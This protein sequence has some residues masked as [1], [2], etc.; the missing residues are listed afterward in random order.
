[1]SILV[2]NAGSSSLKFGLFDADARGTL[3]SGLIDWTADP[4]R[5]SL[6][7]QRPGMDDVRSQVEVSDHRTALVHAVRSLVETEPVTEGRP[8]VIAAIGHRVVHGGAVFRDSV[9]IDDGVKAA[10]AGFAELAPLHNPPALEGIEAA[11]A[12]LPDVPHVAV[13]DTAFHA[14]LP[15]SACIYPL[16]YEWYTDWGIRRFGFHGISHAYCASRAAELLDRDLSTLRLVTCHLGNGCSATAIRGGVSVATT[17]GFTPMEGLMMGSRSGS[18]DPGILV[19][20]QQHRGLTAGQ[21]D[22]LLNH[23]SGLLGVS[24]VSSD[25]RQVEAAAQ[26]GH[27]RARLSLEMYAGR[28][29]SAVGALSVTMGGVDALIFTA[30]VGEHSSSLRAA[31]CEGLQ[32]LGLRLD[33]QRNAACH[34]DAD[35]ATADSP[36][37]ILVI[38]TREELMIARE[39]RRIALG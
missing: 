9:R 22:D 29:R 14:H 33:D 25:F 15:P 7:I 1:M 37:R 19:Y 21:L 4:Q 38:H 35:V 34:P 18:V 6:V 27:D 16:P 31:V 32:C 5:A 23:R 12:I 30:G 3:A 28:V 10:I 2:I 24:G 8:A 39:T 36:A 17:M 20:V 11:Q 26:S 13:F